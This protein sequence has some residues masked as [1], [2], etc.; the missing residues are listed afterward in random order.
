[1]LG[2]VR[3]VAAVKGREEGSGD[4]SPQATR[5]IVPASPPEHHPMCSMPPLMGYLPVRTTVSLHVASKSSSRLL[6]CV[7]APTG[8]APTAPC[9]AEVLL[10]LLPL[11]LPC[12]LL[13]GWA[14]PP[15]TSGSEG[16][17]KLES[18]SALLPSRG[19]VVP[20]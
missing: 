17:S 6:G 3:V 2:R 4:D 16:E 19:G 14:P 7:L 9:V 10:P 15:T 13:A 5:T 20:R 1:M 11:L 18:R 8:P 12:P